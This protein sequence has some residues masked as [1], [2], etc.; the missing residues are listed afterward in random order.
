MANHLNFVHRDLTNEQVAKISAA[1]RKTNSKSLAAKLDTHE[2]VWRMG[3]TPKPN[4]KGRRLP[5]VLPYLCDKKTGELVEHKDGL[6]FMLPPGPGGYMALTAAIVKERSEKLPELSIT[7]KSLSNMT[8]EEKE[9]FPDYVSVLKALEKFVGQDLATLLVT[10]FDKHD[11]FNANQKKK[12]TKFLGEKKPNLQKAIECVVEWL[13][14]SDYKTLPQLNVASRR[15]PLFID[16]Q[17]NKGVNRE[18]AEQYGGKDYTDILDNNP[19]KIF[20]GFHIVGPMGDHIDILEFNR[21]YNTDSIFCLTVRMNGLNFSDNYGT[22]SIITPLMGVKLIN[23]G[24]PYK[25]NSEEDTVPFNVLDMIDDKPPS[26]DVNIN[27]VLGPVEEARKRIKL[28]K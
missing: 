5:T 23:N 12:L 15:R 7:C 11:Y 14:D 18:L 19:N 26:E 25:G 16:P 27:D 22:V 17:K 8:E 3:P 21:I 24:I 20:R 2:L 13:E 9:R 28:G 4:D 10:C 6:E 1:L